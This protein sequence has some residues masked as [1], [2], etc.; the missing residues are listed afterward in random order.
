MVAQQTPLVLIIEDDPQLA[1][2]FSEAVAALGFTT[3]IINDGLI[4]QQQLQILRPR[5]IILDLH[6][7]HVWGNDL[8]TQIR[9]DSRFDD[10]KVLVATAD[11]RLAAQMQEK[12]DLVLLKPIGFRELRDIVNQL[13]M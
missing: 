2:I 10:T 8:L 9:A 7:P 13:E 3:E 4:A 1:L 11:S 12:A 5:L 6:L